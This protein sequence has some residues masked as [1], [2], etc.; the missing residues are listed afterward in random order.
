MAEEAAGERLQLPTRA[1]GADAATDAFLAPLDL[2]GYNYAQW[3]YDRD[4]ARVPSRV[5]VATET[6]PARS[7]EEFQYVN[8]RPYVVGSFIWTAIDYLGESSIGAAGHYTPSALACA[9]Y[10]AQPFPY[11]VSS[12]GD[13]D[14]MGDMRAQAHLRRVMWG[15][16][17]LAMSVQQPGA[18]VTG[19]WGYRDEQQTVRARRG[20]SL[21]TASSG[22]PSHPLLPD[23]PHCPTTT[24]PSARLSLRPLP[25]C[26]PC[27]ACPLPPPTDLPLCLL[28]PPRSGP[29]R[30]SNRRQARRR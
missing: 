26:S 13:L 19:A 9:A 10:C 29:G 16:T 8:A 14:L 7:V 22:I 4:H 27:P 23:H 24:Y 12:C 3:A 1:L 25:P 5:V 15:V 18:E 17:P 30:V 21:R 28:P 20:V 11:H 6:F 2:A